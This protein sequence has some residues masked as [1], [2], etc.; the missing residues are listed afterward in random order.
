MLRG[1]LPLTCCKTEKYHISQ[2]H[3]R[4]PT[5]YLLII[6]DNHPAISLTVIFLHNFCRGS[7]GNTVIWNTLSDNG[8]RTNH[9]TSSD[10]NVWKN[11]NV[12]S[13]KCTLADSDGHECV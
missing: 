13:E 2:M 1:R 6:W 9:T 12:H 8:P 11:Y 3:D 5:H 10:S 7:N 4:L